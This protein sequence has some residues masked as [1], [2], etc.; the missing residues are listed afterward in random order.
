[1]AW[2][3]GSPA[4]V[5]AVTGPDTW[6]VDSGLNMASVSY[7]FKD[8][9]GTYVDI[10]DAL[11]QYSYVDAET[12]NVLMIP[13]ADGKAAHLVGSSKGGAVFTID[14]STH[15]ITHL[16]SVGQQPST[17]LGTDAAMNFGGMCYPGTGDIVVFATTSAANTGNT[18]FLFVIE[19]KP[20]VL[21]KKGTSAL[22]GYN[23]KTG[24]NAWVVLRG[25]DNAVGIECGRGHAFVAS[26]PPPPLLRFSVS[27]CALH[28]SCI[29]YEG[30]VHIC[31]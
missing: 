26:P 27:C 15:T 16:H 21:M 18:D 6:L 24:K 2:Q 20:P 9:T 29:Q 25:T 31:A 17:A 28:A 8:T 14:A 19:G 7:Y 23:Y 13:G 11:G 3:D 10:A 12:N 22:V 1:M 5:T 30:M 4:G